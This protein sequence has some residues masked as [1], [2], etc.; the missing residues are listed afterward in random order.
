MRANS[1]TFHS[2]QLLKAFQTNSAQLQA[3]AKKYLQLNK[4]WCLKGH[5]M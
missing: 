3:P 1:P 5:Q 2:Q 4:N